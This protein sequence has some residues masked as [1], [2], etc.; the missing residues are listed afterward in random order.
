[1]KVANVKEVVEREPFR[2][3][4]VRLS[5]G[6]EYT[7]HSPRQIGATLKYNMIFHFGETTAAR[8]D[9]DS[10]VEIIEST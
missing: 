8:I 7:F 4:I 3:F 6:T 10:I 1:M 9:T 5:N 2:P